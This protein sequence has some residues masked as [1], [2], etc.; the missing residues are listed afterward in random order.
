MCAA[1]AIIVTVHMEP[2]AKWALYYCIP[3]TMTLE[4]FDNRGNRERPSSM[5]EARKFGEKQACGSV[6][7]AR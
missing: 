2:S 5:I 3:L 1:R 4:P 6:V 7:V